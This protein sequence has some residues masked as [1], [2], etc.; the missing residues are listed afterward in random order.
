MSKV[1]AIVL[2]VVALVSC[3]YSF[4]GISIPPEVNT[5][6]V[7]PFSISAQTA[8][9]AIEVQFTERLRDK[10]RNESR[11]RYDTDS[12][13]IVFSGKISQYSISAQSPEEGAV[14]AFNKLTIGVQINYDDLLNEDNS[15]TKTYSWFA[16]FDATADLPSI[17]AD[18]I[19]DIYEQ[20]AEQIFNEAFTDW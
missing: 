17:E 14:S 15:W 20:L 3:S 16:D 4:R 10:V 13:D 2:M 1:V 5:F 11:L 19:E 12:P 7:E 9:Q 6:S 8:P 18:L